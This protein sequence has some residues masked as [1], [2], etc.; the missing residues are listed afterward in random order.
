M[1]THTE[2]HTLTHTSIDWYRSQTSSAT[3]THRLINW[4]HFANPLNPVMKQSLGR[5]MK[6]SFWFSQSTFYMSYKLNANR[7][8]LYSTASAYLRWDCLYRS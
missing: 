3:V 1:H 4:A 5:Q 6:Q 7:W 8:G 2:T